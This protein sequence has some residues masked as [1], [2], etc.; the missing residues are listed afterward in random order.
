MSD[1]AANFAGAIVAGALAGQA[2][3]VASVASV[4]AAVAGKA[5]SGYG[6][7]KPTYSKLHMVFDSKPRILIV[8]LNLDVVIGSVTLETDTTIAGIVRLF[9]APAYRKQGIGSELVRQCMS[10]AVEDETFE[11]ISLVVEAK[12]MGVADFYKKLGFSPAF[13][14][15]DGDILFTKPIHRG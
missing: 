13:E 1:D 9:V 3:A 12:N 14:W 15:A 11:A 7:L 2:Q 4:G 8:A 10:I 5:M 6:E